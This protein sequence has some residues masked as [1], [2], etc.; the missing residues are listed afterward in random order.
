MAKRMNVLLSEEAINIIKEYQETNR[1][2][3]RDTAVEYFILEHG[4]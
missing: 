4:R 2:A 3:N 1:L